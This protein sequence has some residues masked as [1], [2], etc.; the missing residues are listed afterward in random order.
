MRLAFARCP[1]QDSIHDYHVISALI[2][3]NSTIAR[4][5]YAE[6]L[7]REYGAPITRRSDDINSGYVFTGRPVP[8]LRDMLSEA[9]GRSS[10]LGSRAFL[11]VWAK[12]AIAHSGS[13]FRRS[14]G[15]EWLLTDEAAGS[16]GG[17]VQEMPELRAFLESLLAPAFS[18]DDFQYTLTAYGDRVAFHVVTVLGDHVHD[19]SR[20]LVPRR[21]LLTHAA[22]EFGLFTAREV[23]ELEALLNDKRSTEAT[24][25]AF[26]D[27][28][29][30]F[31]RRGD[32]R[33]VHSHVCLAHGDTGSLIPDF[34]LTDRE[35]AK[36]TIVQLKLPRAKLV[37]RQRNRDRFAAA[38]TEAIAQLNMYRGWFRESANRRRLKDIVGMQIYEPRLTVIIGRSSEFYDEFD[39][40]R[41]SATQPDI[42]VVTYDDILLYASR[43]RSLLV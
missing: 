23:E 37:R 30:H 39:R 6:V 26:F 27:R 11:S 7:K 29:P 17:G 42:E 43:R 4:H 10:M 9:A 28:Y 18:D 40:Q 19:T 22:G 21:T 12:Y 14:F 31:L 32:Y 2:E 13:R 3:L 16:A 34:I 35:M 8:S 15:I 33:E 38:I 5:P 24:F 36:A 41:L 1:R 20:L 25:Q